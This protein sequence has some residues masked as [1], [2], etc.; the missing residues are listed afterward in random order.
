[1]PDHTS[2]VTSPVRPLASPREPGRRCTPVDLWDA[3]LRARIDLAEERASPKRHRQRTARALLVGA[4]DAYVA[5]L[6]ERGHPVPYALRD[7]LRL[8]RLTCTSH[9]DA[10][11]RMGR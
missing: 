10:G 11:E 7:E 8:Q 2:I 9:Y 5:N 1:M 6:G 4:L 3:V